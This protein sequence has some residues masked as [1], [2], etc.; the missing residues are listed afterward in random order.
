MQRRQ[1]LQPE[2]IVPSPHGGVFREMSFVSCKTHDAS[3]DEL[4]KT[5]PVEVVLEN[6]TNHQQ[7]T[8]RAK[9]LFGSDGARSV[10]RKCIA[11]GEPGD[12]EWK[13]K[14]TMQGEATDIIWVGLISHLPAVAL[15][16]SLEP[17]RP[18]PLTCFCS[19]FNFGM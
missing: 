12:G 1:H 18:D 16:L 13:G 11:G 7:F 9:Y 4:A 14:I 10:V 15:V 17:S 19:A 8:V 6:K 3:H 2:E 5:H